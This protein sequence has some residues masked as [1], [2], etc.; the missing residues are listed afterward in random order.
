M[1]QI[2]SL[3]N[4][5]LA[6]IRTGNH[7]TPECGLLTS[8]GT[9]G[10]PTLNY[11]LP[12]LC[13]AARQFC[14][15]RGDLIMWCTEDHPAHSKGTVPCEEWLK[16]TVMLLLHVVKDGLRLSSCSTN[17]SVFCT[18]DVAISVGYTAYFAQGLGKETDLG[19]GEIQQ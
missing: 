10:Q 3:M 18:V 6:E 17:R 5:N 11:S 1:I 13:L 4:S 19:K 2:T 8:A 7:C 15:H 9:V 12:L 14:F 16:I